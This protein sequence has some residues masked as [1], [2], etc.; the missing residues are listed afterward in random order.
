MSGGDALHSRPSPPP[1]RL[2]RPRLPPH[3]SSPPIIR[4]ATMRGMASRFVT[5]TVLSPLMAMG[6]RKALDRSLCRVLPW[7]GKAL[8]YVPD[9]LFVPFAASA[10]SAVL[11]ILLD[12]AQRKKAR[13]CAAPAEGSHHSSDTPR[14]CCPVLGCQR[15]SVRIVWIRR[16]S[17]L[18][19]TEAVPTQ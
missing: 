18:P 7:I 1:R 17:A 16:E 3:P 6:A 12:M 9:S 4:R 15:Q 13:S 19:S 5:I 8:G 14:C 2:A 10:M 11:P